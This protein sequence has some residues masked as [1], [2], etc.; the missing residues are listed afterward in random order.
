MKKVKKMPEEEEE[1]EEDFLPTN[2][3]YYLGQGP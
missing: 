1:T 2:V 3:E